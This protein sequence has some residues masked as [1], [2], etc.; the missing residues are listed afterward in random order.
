MKH[1][2]HPLGAP[3]P[4][5]GQRAG[6]RHDEPGAQAAMSGFLRVLERLVPPPDDRMGQTRRAWPR[7][8]L[9]E[10]P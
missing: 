7:T 1:L 5:P 4:M 8:I 9:Q 3:R 6:P 10:K 2:I